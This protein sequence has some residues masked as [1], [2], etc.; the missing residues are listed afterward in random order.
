MTNATQEF[1]RVNAQYSG[2]KT[3][4]N[5]LP[6]NPFKFIYNDSNKHGCY[7]KNILV[8]NI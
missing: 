2:F 4:K 3:T 7:F 8:S 5:T 6:M 1:N